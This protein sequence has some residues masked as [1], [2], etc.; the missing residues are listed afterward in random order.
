MPRKRGNL[1]KIRLKKPDDLRKFVVKVIND[2]NEGTITESKAKTYGYLGNCLTK[3]FETVE[4][5]ARVEQLEEA[6]SQSNK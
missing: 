2:L 4:L 6:L 1:N 3:I 5:A